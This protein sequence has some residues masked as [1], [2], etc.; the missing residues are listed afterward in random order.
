[1]GGCLS[2]SSEFT[3]ASYGSETPPPRGAR[4]LGG[5]GAT[6]TED[7]REAVRRAALERQE[8]NNPAM[9]RAAKLELIGKLTELYNRTGQGPPF[10][11]GSLELSKLRQLYIDM[12]GRN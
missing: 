2:S 6:N 12:G 10:N 8:K 4:T 5:A 1:M 7:P 11:L 3:G 9:A